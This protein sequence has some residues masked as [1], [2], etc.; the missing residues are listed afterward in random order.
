MTGKKQQS[1]ENQELACLAESQRRLLAQIDDPIKEQ[2][3]ELAQRSKEA[4]GAFVDVTR[5]AMPWLSAEPRIREVAIR[6]MFPRSIAGPYQ[7]DA[8]MRRLF[9]ANDRRPIRTVL[10]SKADFGKGLPSTIEIAKAASRVL[11]AS[12]STF[13]LEVGKHLK[14]LETY[15]PTAADFAVEALQDAFVGLMQSKYGWGKKGR[16][17]L[18]E[19]SG[20]AKALLEK[21]ERQVR[22]SGWTELLKTAG[23]GWL[24][25]GAAGRPS[26]AELDENEKAFREC[27]TILTQAINDKDIYGG[28]AIRARDV[29]RSWSGKAEYKR[30]KRDGLSAPP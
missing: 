17:T 25:K 19:V 9:L 13:F 30:S 26:K 4:A 10:S 20:M 12:G 28:N 14:H 22:K 21:E 16:P 11:E 29:L 5:K 8:L 18:G 1:Q 7:T 6:A 15:E 24:P 23:L 3:A 27:H 2:L